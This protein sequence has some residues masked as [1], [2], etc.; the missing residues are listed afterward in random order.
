MVANMIKT[1]YYPVTAEAFL[2]AT[3]GRND[4]RFVMVGRGP[5]LSMMQELAEKEPSLKVLPGVSFEEMLKLYALADVYV[6]GGTEPASTAL[7]IG[8]IANLPLISSPAVGCYDDVVRDGET[9]YSVADYL[10]VPNWEQA[11]VR[12]LEGKGAWI[13]MGMRARALS[14]KLDSDLVVAKFCEKMSM[15]FKGVED[16]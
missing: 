11:F 7:I 1:R 5:E 2:H 15:V 3:H 14:R 13:T 8:A 4:V 6:H 16:V 12:A 10:S 9:G